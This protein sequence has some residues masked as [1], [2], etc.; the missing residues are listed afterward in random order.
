[1]GRVNR[2]IMIQTGLGMETLSKKIPKA[3]RAG[4]MAGHRA[5][6]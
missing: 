5:S 6:A 1:M 3:K 2:R 4:G